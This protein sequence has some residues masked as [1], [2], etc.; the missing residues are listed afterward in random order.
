MSLYRSLHRRFGPS[1]RLSTPE[2]LRSRRAALKLTLAASAGLLLSGPGAMALPACR[3]GKRVVVIG[4]GLA[5]LACAHE[6][7]AAGHQVTVLEARSRLGGRVMTFKDLVPGKFVEGGGEFIGAN[8]ATWAQY[9]LK[10]GLEL[11]DVPDEVAL[12]RPLR[13]GGRT[14]DDAEAAGVWERLEHSL[15][16]L[17]KLATAVDERRP[18]T[19]ERAPALDSQSLAIWLA[20]L[21][22]DDLTNRAV[23]AE[24]EG[25]NAVSL[26][27]SSLLAML[28]IVKGGGLEKYWTDSEAFRC[29]GGTQQLAERLAEAIGR[30]RVVLR[31][32]VTGLS[33][34]DS[35][36]SV[37]RADGQVHECDLVVVATPPTIWR[38]LYFEP[39]LPPEFSM[40]MGPATMYLASLRERVW[41]ARGHSQHAMTDQSISRTWEATAGQT[42]PPPADDGATGRPPPPPLDRVCLAAFSAGPAADRA[43]VPSG[44]ERIVQLQALLEQVHPGT[45]AAFLTSRLVNWP[46]ESWTFGGY[47]FPAPNQLVATGPAIEKGFGPVRFCGEHTCY[48]FAGYMEGALRSGVE[49][50]RLISAE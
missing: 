46:S 4:A 9:A 12:P 28:A 50:A 36:C 19:S 1:S 37:K 14:L 10:F 23:R 49:L 24:L 8:H 16:S 33:V 31:A 21:G 40:Q 6:L 35:G 29:R 47:S 13:L 7:L 34:K 25:L 5:G 11:M 26:E 18:W 42:P 27:Q 41:A 48:A 2:F 32:P 43:L 44:D 38:R 15:G 30:E 45:Q 22:A 39:A 3:N 17:T 20:E